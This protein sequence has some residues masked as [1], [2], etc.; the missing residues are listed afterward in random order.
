MYLQKEQTQTESETG[1]L[2]E[3]PPRG[4]CAATLQHTT[5]RCNTLH[6][7]QHTAT[8]HSELHRGATRGPHNTTT[9]KILRHT[10]AFTTTHC[11]TLQHT[12]TLC[13]TLQHAATCEL[14]RKT[15]CDPQKNK[16][17][18]THCNTP[19]LVDYTRDHLL[20]TTLQHSNTLQHT[21]TRCD[22]WVAQDITSW[23]SRCSIWH[24][25]ETHCNR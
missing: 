24:N 18:P 17:W 25:T 22:R 4:Q 8:Y 7:T 19:P 11:N 5:T 9:C 15:N 12:T 2:Y 10:A 3:W 14:H 23:A 6:Y 16:L 1:E 21:A 13:D 20:S